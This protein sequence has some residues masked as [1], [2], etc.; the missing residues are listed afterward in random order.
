[1][2]ISK[3]AL[4]ILALTSSVVSAGTMGPACTAEDVTIPCNRHGWDFGAKALYLQPSYT[5]DFSVTNFTNA[6][7]ITTYNE[8]VPGWSFGFMFEGSY[9]FGSGKDINLNWYHQG[10]TTTYSELTGTAAAPQTLTVELRH[11]WDAVNAEFGQHVDYGEH[12][13]I[14]FHGG[15]Q[16]ARI[17]HNIYYNSAITTPADTIFMRFKGFGPR[18]G[19]DMSYD[20]NNGLAVYAKTAAAVLAGSSDYS[21]VTLGLIAP[22][23]GSNGSNTGV[24][25][26]LEGKLG[27]TYSCSLAQGDLSLDAGYMWQN[28]FNAQTYR[29][30]AATGISQTTDYGLQGPYLGIKYIGYI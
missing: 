21:T 22:T 3:T 11:K 23:G 5:G 18:A 25:P 30:A 4:A 1:M 2:K 29:L 7:N 14:R 27:F 24:V 17:N 16:Y 8:L 13:N 6:S 26:E 28:Y 10:S 20:W 15:A 12:K 19:L 9:H